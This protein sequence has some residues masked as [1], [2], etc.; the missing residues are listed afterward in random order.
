M[1]D[2]LVGPR[3]CSVVGGDGFHVI[4]E[5][6][7][8]ALGVCVVRCGLGSQP[9]HHTAGETLP[10][11]ARAHADAEATC[12]LSLGTRSTLGAVGAFVGVAVGGAEQ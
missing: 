11:S 12:P 9:T 10:P 7:H 1:A 3:V 5:G 4:E 8:D 6:L 2:S